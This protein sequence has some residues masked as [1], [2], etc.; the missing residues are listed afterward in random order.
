VGSS[1]THEQL[2]EAFSIHPKSPYSE[3]DGS[4]GALLAETSTLQDLL[5]AGGQSLAQLAC[6][7]PAAPEARPARQH[8]HCDAAASKLEALAAQVAAVRQYTH[9][10]AALLADC[11][12]RADS[13]RRQTQTAQ[14]EACLASATCM[15]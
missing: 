14:G 3:A 1:G 7:S 9:Q 13:L 11:R 15:R 12:A 6:S 4:L 2:P 8:S 5:A 10:Q